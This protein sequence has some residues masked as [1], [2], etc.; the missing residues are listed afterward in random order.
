M[1]DDAAVWALTPFE[2][3][4]RMAAWN[5]SEIRLDERI[6]AGAWQGAMLQRARRLPD[7]D[8]WM[9]RDPEAAA[10]EAVEEGA[11]RHSALVEMGVIEEAPNADE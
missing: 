11:A 2:L 10:R 9:M 4:E 3:G 1:I 5:E 7:W 6:K 8:R